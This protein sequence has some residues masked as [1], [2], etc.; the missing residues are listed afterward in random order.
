MSS[1]RWGL[2][3]RVAMVNHHGNGDDAE[4]LPIRLNNSQHI[5]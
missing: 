4:C 1:D 3:P 2:G 5:T